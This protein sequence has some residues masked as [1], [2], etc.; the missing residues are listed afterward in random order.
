MFSGQLLVLKG[1]HPDSV[2]EFASCDIFSLDGRRLPYHI[3]DVPGSALYASVINIKDDIYVV[4]VGEKDVDSEYR[5]VY[6]LQSLS[7]WKRCSDLLQDSQ[8]HCACSVGDENIVSIIGDKMIQIYDVKRDMWKPGTPYPGDIWAAACCEYEGD[9]IVSG[10]ECGYRRTRRVW[11]ITINDSSEVWT[12]MPS[13]VE[14]KSLHCMVVIGPTICV[15][16]GDPTTTSIEMWNPGDPVFTLLSFTLPVQKKRFCATVINNTIFLPPGQPL[17]DS[18]DQNSS[19]VPAFTMDAK[20]LIP[21]GWLDDTLLILTFNSD[22]MIQKVRVQKMPLACTYNWG[23]AVTHAV[24]SVVFIYSHRYI[25]NGCALYSLYL[26]LFFRRSSPPETLHSFFSQLADQPAQTAR[27]KCTHLVK[28][29]RWLLS[30]HG[31]VTES[32][33]TRF[34]CMIYRAVL[35]GSDLKLCQD[36]LQSFIEDGPSLVHFKKPILEFPEM[37]QEQSEE[38]GNSNDSKRDADI[39]QYFIKDE[40]SQVPVKEPNIEPFI[41]AYLSQRLQEKEEGPA[42]SNESQLLIR[43]E[44]KPFSMVDEDLVSDVPESGSQN[45]QEMWSQATKLLLNFRHCRMFFEVSITKYLIL[46]EMMH[47]RGAT[48]LSDTAKHLLEPKHRTAELPLQRIIGKNPLKYIQLLSV[49]LKMM[50]PQDLPNILP[51]ASELIQLLCEMVPG[52]VFHVLQNVHFKEVFVTSLLAAI[53]AGVEF[54][55]KSGPCTLY[56]KDR[57]LHCPVH[58]EGCSHCDFLYYQEHQVISHEQLERAHFKGYISAA[59]GILITEAVTSLFEQVNNLIDCPLLQF[60]VKVTGSVR[61]RTKVGRL[62]ELDIHLEIDLSD[63]VRYVTVNY[64]GNAEVRTTYP[65]E[66]ETRCTVYSAGLPK[67]PILQDY[68]TPENWLLITSQDLSAEDPTTVNAIFSFYSQVTK[69]EKINNETLG[70]V[71]ISTL[72]DYLD[73]VDWNKLPLR[74]T[75]T[76]NPWKLLWLAEGPYYGMKIDLDVVPI[77]DLSRLGILI[78]VEYNNE[79]NNDYLP[80]VVRDRQ[81]LI[82]QEPNWYPMKLHMKWGKPGSQHRLCCTVSRSEL[83]IM[84]SLPPVLLNAVRLVKWLIEVDY[85]QQGAHYADADKPLTSYMV[86]NALFW[87]LHHDIKAVKLSKLAREETSKDQDTNVATLAA[88]KEWAILILEFL[89]EQAELGTMMPSFF[90]SNAFLF[91]DSHIQQIID[92]CNRYIQ[93]LNGTTAELKFTLVD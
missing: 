1:N 85:W 42:Q 51:E 36:V 88:A 74:V 80:Q 5:A 18:I 52:S 32:E 15:L 31:S 8:W 34:T 79:D 23:S 77:I 24:M 72:R 68:L 60:K 33:F 45:R 61:E 55:H 43:C 28:K 90:I 27:K 21:G 46:I 49:V 17:H 25:S 7:S 11:R 10:G 19:W 89:K 93:F 87:I 84:D 58:K 57:R 2:Y 62:D 38:L 75:N 44:A 6:K 53:P 30:Q 76:A 20:M 37:L 59:E 12:E 56:W 22:N 40:P 14:E 35:L 78:G 47:G 69:F 70:E 81:G 16:G 4:G 50:K 83:E 26:L 9:V 91:N 64:A 66:K 82:L 92:T 71:I 13:M 63:H 73:L 65:L 67:K 3:P 39:L 86:K 29:L 54:D 48:V 41:K